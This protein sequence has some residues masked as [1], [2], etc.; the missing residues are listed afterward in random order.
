M[1]RLSCSAAS[2]VCLL[3]SFAQAAD[4]APVAPPHVAAPPVAANAASAP[5]VAERPAAAPAV[6][7]PAPVP[8]PAASIAKAWAHQRH[9]PVREIEVGPPERR[10]TRVFVPVKAED[11][12]SF[13]ETFGNR[14]QSLLLKL[15]S[16]DKHLHTLIG[17]DSY[18]WA[19]KSDWGGGGHGM[20]NDGP[21]GPAMVVGLTAD[22][23]AHMKQWFAHREDPNDSL[24]AHPCGATC[25]DFL[26]NIEIG[27]G[28]DG[29]HTLRPIAAA[30][31]AAAAAGAG[32]GGGSAA[33]PAGRRLFDM[34]GIARSKDG[35]NMTYNLMHAATDRVQVVGV[36]MGGA[37]AM[38]QQVVVENGRRVVKNVP[39]EGDPI[40]RFATM[41]DAELLGPLPPQGVAGVVRPAR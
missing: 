16:G 9:L 35:R 18:L 8:L 26:G 36:P 31:I 12:P 22:E 29:A 10:V 5:H 2:A 24:Y 21:D 6:A 17:E 34:L 28:A 41:T 23:D 27:P 37:A 38:R 3:A 40:E 20:A 19:R 11:W 33:I 7:A 15:R 1:K 14:P 39:V 32:K 30:E 25:M 13:F 4:R